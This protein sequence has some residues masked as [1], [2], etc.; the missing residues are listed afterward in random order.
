MFLYSSLGK[1]P[2]CL[3][4][5]W[6]AQVWNKEGY[7]K[8]PAKCDFFIYGYWRCSFDSKELK[9]HYHTIFFLKKK[10]NKTKQNHIVWL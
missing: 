8:P 9:A 10:Q 3:G 1:Q 6:T 5:P 2:K 4:F 7:G